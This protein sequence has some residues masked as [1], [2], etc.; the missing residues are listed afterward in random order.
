MINYNNGLRII[1][2]TK[3]KFK[4]Y[5]QLIKSRQTCLLL[6]TGL[7]GYMSARCPVLPW[8]TF[9]ELFGSL[10]LA[11]SGSTVLNMVYDR[12]ID[13]R[14]NRTAHR[15]I[16]SGK[17][18]VNEALI[19]GSSLSFLGLIWAFDLSFIYGLIVFA[20]LFFDV[21][22]YTIWLKRRT[23]WS[24][25]WGGISGAMPILA[26]RALGLGGIDII[27]ILLS[28]A[29]LLWIPTHIITF[30]MRYSEDYYRAGIPTFPSTYGYKNS[31]LIVAVSILCATLAIALGLFAL[32]LSWGYLRL[33]AVLTVGILGLG[34]VGIFRPSE[35]INWGLFKFASLYMLG[36]MIMVIVGVLS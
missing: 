26:G 34:I 12:N 31:R 14:M 27:G 24:I 36:S 3:T 33:L 7:T 2:I 4:L 1:E 8:N 11:I 30:S 15:P 20:G 19:L 25:V 22:V 32:G 18:S 29:V 5:L 28:L 23:A 17:I 35:R 13:A 6:F 16:P 10:F 9:I 21:V